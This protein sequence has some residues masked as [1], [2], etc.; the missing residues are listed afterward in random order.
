M[1]LGKTFENRFLWV[2]TMPVQCLGNPWQQDWLKNNGG[3]EVGYPVELDQQI[4]AEFFKR[5]GAAI[6]DSQV[7][8]LY[9]AVCASCSCPTGKLIFLNI[10]EVAYPIFAE[11]GFRVS[12][13][14]LGLTIDRDEYSAGD[15][16]EFQLT[17]DSRLSFKSSGYDPVSQLLQ[18]TR[19]SGF[20]IQRLENGFWS[21]VESLRL[22]VPPV[23]FTIKPAETL[24][25]QWLAP[26]NLDG[27]FRLVLLSTAVAGDNR[28]VHTISNRFILK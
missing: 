12:G 9:E 28:T 20:Q 17:N 18:V 4:L 14:N 21:T 19:G 3:R 13:Q 15:T 8:Q 22:D 10:H 23:E 24:K 7:D 26:D 27:V 2:E 11:N 5:Q 16:V 6:L 1:A 25:G